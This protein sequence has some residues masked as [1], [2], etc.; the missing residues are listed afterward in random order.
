M[1]SHLTKLKAFFPFVIL[2][3]IG[4]LVSYF[5]TD[6][7]WTQMQWELPGTKAEYPLAQ[8]MRPI[9]ISIGCFLP[10]VAY[11]IYACSS[12]LDR[13]MAKLFFEKFVLCTSILTLIFILGDFAENA[14]EF[15]EFDN[16][17]L[18][19]VRFYILQ[20]P[21]MLNLFLPY[22]SLLAT[23]WTLSKLSGGSEITGMLQSGRSL[24]RITFPIIVGAVFVSAYLGIFGFH[25]A[26]NSTLYRKL[27]FASL[28]TTKNLET[29]PYAKSC[30]Y[31]SDKANRIWNI[32]IPP[33]IDS[34]GAPLKD[35]HIIQFSAP[36]I[37]NYELFADSATWNSAT[38]TWSFNN[39][40]KRV[41][42]QRTSIN[43]IPEFTGDLVPVLH[44][45][46][47]E[48]PWQLISPF[49]RADTQG[50]PAISELL[51]NKTTDTKTSRILLTEW[52]VRIAKIFSCILL[53]FIAIPTSITFQRRSTM[54]GIGIA[55]FLAAM[56]LFLF[57]VVPTLA[58]A[59]LLP[60]WLGAWLPNIIY[61]LIG[62]YLFQSRL[63]MRTVRECLSGTTTNAPILESKDS[64]HS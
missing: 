48:T 53:A 12:I 60:C 6:R 38:R 3:V 13:Y 33:N 35:V 26:P 1:R 8:T 11:L 5:L 41:H 36:G 28:N 56:M 58:T 2:L 16:P 49:F 40:T 64:A 7:E 50:T 46:F 20:L 55:I 27:L 9:L 23:L 30:R 21:M 14:N 18:G 59:G 31:K 25:W 54:Q 61:L 34:P 17:I 63:A 37:I 4:S 57:E 22:T 44:T 52:H 29:N 39:A 15:A 42:P 62:I 10:A 51:N 43:D 19:T 47:E 32:R 45:D 24:L